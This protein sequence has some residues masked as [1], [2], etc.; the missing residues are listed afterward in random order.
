MILEDSLLCHKWRNMTHLQKEH[1][2]LK[3]RR[4]IIQNEVSFEFLENNLYFSL[5]ILPVN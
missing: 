5:S 2:K 1:N 3:I 4:N